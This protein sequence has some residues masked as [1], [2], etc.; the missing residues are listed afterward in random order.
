MPIAVS[1]QNVNNQEQSDLIVPLSRAQHL[2]WLSQRVAAH[3]PLYNLAVTYTIRGPLGVERF[4]SA[5][6]ELVGKS[7]IL[8]SV[9]VDVDSDKPALRRLTTMRA[10]CLLE[11][12]PD[13]HSA[14]RW[15][16][17]RSQVPLDPR[18]RMFDCA[19]L[20]IAE[21]HHV[22]YWCQHHLSSDGSNIPLVLD[23]IARFYQL[24]DETG[25]HASTS[26]SAATPG[27]NS[28]APP[29]YFEF[30]RHQQAQ[31]GTARRQKIT[32][33]WQKKSSSD[34]DVPDFFGRPFD[35]SHAK[36]RRS[37]TL[38]EQQRQSIESILA[39]PGFSHLN[40]ELSLFVLMATVMIVTGY[41]IH[42]NPGM[43]L[44]FP[45]HVRQNQSMQKLLGMVI[46]LGF[47]KL[48]LQPADSFRSLAKSIKRDLLEAFSHMEPG[49]QTRQTQQS[50]SSSLNILSA[51]VDA[52]CGM[53]VKTKWH[54]PGYSDANSQL[55][56]NLTDF[57]GDGQFELSLDMGSSVF[58][59]AGQDTYIAVFQSTLAALLLNP[60]TDVATFELYSAQEKQ[61]LLELGHGAPAAALTAPTLHEHFSAQ[62][63]RT[64]HALAVKQG[65][66]SLTY[67]ELET[68]AD[69]LASYLQS[70]GV[71]P[72][73]R[74]G[75]C[76]KRSISMYAAM[77]GCMKVHAVFV[78]LDPT[79][80]A[81]RLSYM[82]SDSGAKLLI[83]TA[84]TDIEFDHAGVQRVTV[85]DAIDAGSRNQQVSRDRKLAES[86]FA[87]SDQGNRDAWYIMYTSGST[88][89]P[90]G[91]VGTHAATLNR[92]YWMWRRHPFQIGEV[93]CQKTAL[94]FVDSIWELFGPLLQGVPVVVIPD[95][96]V[97]D[98]FQFVDVLDYEQISRLVVVPSFLSV[99][100]DCDADITNRLRALEVCVVSGEPLPMHV[101][102]SFLNKLGHCQLLNLYGSTEVTADVTADAVTHDK[103]AVKMPIGRPI[104]GVDI[105]IVDDHLNPVPKGAVGEICVSGAGLSGGYFNQSELNAEKFIDHPFASGRL[106][107]TGDL[108]RFNDSGLIEHHGRRDAQL[109]IRGHRIESAE[110]E[111][112]LLQFDGIRT[113]VLYAGENDQLVAFYVVTTGESVDET[114]LLYH[115]EARLPEYMIPQL[116]QVAQIP[117]LGNGKI[118]RKA[119]A[120]LLPQNQTDASTAIEP[121]TDTEAV[122]V[123]IWQNT[124]AIENVDIHADFFDLGGNS[125]AAMRIMVGAR[126]AGFALSLK[127]ILEIGT[128]AG[129]G[130]E[131]DNN[132]VQH[133]IE[134][135][136][137][138]AMD[139]S[140]E[141][142]A[143]KDV[144]QTIEQQIAANPKIGGK[145]NVADMFHLTASQKGILFHTLLQGE[146]APSYL[147]QIRCDLVGDMDTNLF[148]Q[149]W[150]VVVSRHDMLRSLIVY[151]GLQEPVQVIAKKGDAGIE[152]HDFRH[153]DPDTSSARCD[154]IAR[155]KLHSPIA[156]DR[157]PMFRA[158]AIQTAP[159]STHL[160]LDWHHILMDGWSLAV[161][162]NEVLLVYASLKNGQD[163]GLPEPGTFRDH[164]IAL[165]QQDSDQVQN[166][167]REKLSGFTA[168]T[169]ISDQSDSASELY[170]EANLNV[171]LDATSTER[172][173][174][175]ARRCRVT[176]NT[177]IQAAWA[178]LLAK[179]NDTEDVMFGFAV[180][181]RSSGISNYEN[182]VGMFVNSLPMRINCAG[183]IAVVDWLQQVQNEQMELVQYENSS[184][185]DI[186]RASVLPA[187]APMFDSLMVFQNVPR[188][189][190]SNEF[191]L[192]IHNRK[193]HENSPTP[194]TIEVFPGQQLEV[195][196]MY[197]EPL[198]SE[199][200]VPQIIDHFI[201]IIK[202]ISANDANARVS[203]IGLM[204]DDEIRAMNA[205]FNQ[206]AKAYPDTSDVS[207]L[208]WQQAMQSPHKTAASFG[209][210]DVTYSDLIR[211]A[212]QLANYLR[213]QGLK[214]NDL[215]AV[216][217]NRQENLL[218]A[219]LAV[220]RA[221]AA[222]LPLDPDYPQ[223]RIDTILENAA[224]VYTLTS[225]DVAV[226][227]NGTADAVLYLDSQWQQVA[228]APLVKSEVVATVDDLAY[229]IYTSGSTG[230]PKGV[231]ITRKNM[232]NF[233]FAMR[234][235]PGIGSQDSLLAVTTVSFDIAVL[236]L[237]L[238]L[239]CG[240]RV[241]VAS[242]DMAFDGFAM[243]ERITQQGITMMQATPTTWRL[244]LA[245][246]WQ[247]V[248]G[249]KALVGGEALPRDLAAALLPCVESLWNMYGPTETTVWSTC[250]HITDV[251]GIISIGRPIANTEVLILDGEQ[252][253]CPVNIPGELCIAGDGV[254]LGY[255]D[256][257]EL[258]AEK[259]IAHPLQP[260][261]PGRVYRTGDLARWM[262]DGRLECLGRI[263]SQVKLRGFRIELGDIETR[264]S[265]V[266]GVDHAIVNLVRSAD[267]EYLAAYLVPDDGDEDRIPNELVLRDYLRQYLP[268]YM[269]PSTYMFLD[270][271][272]RLP[273]GKVDRK[274]LPV[275][276]TGTGNTAELATVDVYDLPDNQPVTDSEKQLSEL[277]EKVLR[278][279]RISVN[280]NFFDLGGN[281]ISAMQIMSACKKKG[282]DVTILD[283]FNL[284][285]IRRCAEAADTRS[286]AQPSLSDIAALAVDKP[287]TVHDGD[288]LARIAQL[289][290]SNG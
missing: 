84:G 235:I 127:Q 241:D 118:N 260:D 286:G 270:K 124:L 257:D 179:Y 239:I 275:P 167:W 79:Y 212:D 131:I 94:S 28:V 39:Q 238:P 83:S 210:V 186:Q 16:A 271:V 45:A 153:L 203:D 216:C 220:M 214:P 82:L 233:L 64:P 232:V 76:C 125:I 217:L 87:G 101:A 206:T 170:A 248:P 287:S 12:T 128:I 71:V 95:E 200:P 78:P 102:L 191:P 288:D 148:R 175:F 187:N 31:D 274:S 57:A 18:Q 7:D 211:R 234:D 184:L 266:D 73:D 154:D 88:G 139:V 66:D 252:R 255:V 289:L 261:S 226:A 199:H 263:D 169:P 86:A 219:L 272:P 267:D 70:Q 114:R 97:L 265:D 98:I 163:H 89:L 155:Q 110:I 246:D 188:L 150:D 59:V 229:V 281:S 195:Q 11:Q 177:V 48:E 93:C 43:K 221:G 193:V 161:M 99:L 4:A 129:I 197:I 253:L 182:T 208:I 69:A 258:T 264:L 244:L 41:R 6:D 157:F 10:D 80:P 33:Y 26:A 13:E 135:A 133:L 242:R 14:A 245:A 164:V 223:H 284:G 24:T 147:A 202:S 256:R 92:F 132:P 115:L 38:D 171:L 37:I 152:M 91:V 268:L 134:S 52:F 249:F 27:D 160:I 218:V 180:T 198:F 181:G 109:K 213:T 178:L 62:V 49:V 103:L 81:D 276:H 290:K 36:V 19:L 3:K 68:H 126:K 279:D 23:Y 74:V 194:I 77:I 1:P 75:L 9:I 192:E 174:E 176:P 65:S 282:L 25:A 224:V 149:A 123:E 136:S 173:Y 90:K 106:F 236:E 207:D 60:D 100:L 46:G 30:L 61:A 278:R 8:Q 166:F 35:H 143:D 5:C 204:S 47:L 121:R 168:T 254:T 116:V 67:A 162:S 228:D 189:S 156:L 17:S 262:D 141:Q 196:V 215:V 56:I 50:F 2:I 240:A 20:T 58:D 227:I 72:G 230:V 104:D 185:V 108:G 159:Q 251:S 117:L 137:H 40:R 158:T 165:N 190:V 32:D 285:T 120:L 15:V 247:G 122:L 53:P 172:L 142:S 145:D 51:P 111:N 273:N 144:F 183:S 280:S 107:K 55:D 283:M 140:V 277:W 250:E 243:V 113:A 222:Y 119:L 201:H 34:H 105:Y 205:A 85:E 29:S 21:D 22:F 259:F 269:I 225:S 138:K 151:E 42:R 96:Q 130:I 209:S 44:G 237:F 54:F 231:R 63:R 112:T 146:G